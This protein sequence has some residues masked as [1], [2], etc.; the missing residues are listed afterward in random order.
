MDIE[1]EVGGSTMPAPRGGWSCHT[2]HLDPV[3]AGVGDSEDFILIYLK[4]CRQRL[5]GLDV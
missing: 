4:G 5:R 1:K 3:P 2:L